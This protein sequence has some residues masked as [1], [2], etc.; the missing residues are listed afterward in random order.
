MK[1][2]IIQQSKKIASISTPLDNLLYYLD[3]GF[4]DTK[5]TFYTT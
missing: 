3:S 5:P 2:E 4:K 1:Q